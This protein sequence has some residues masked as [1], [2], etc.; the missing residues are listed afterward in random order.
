M[1]KILDPNRSQTDKKT[2]CPCVKS[3][4]YCEK[5]QPERGQ[6]DRAKGE[7]PTVI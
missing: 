1:E 3:P 7:L 5:L 4:A 2:L 6:I